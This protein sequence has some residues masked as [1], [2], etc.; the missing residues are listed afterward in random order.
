[1][2]TEIS[3]ISFQAGDGGGDRYRTIISEVRNV[4]SV[5]LAPLADLV[6]FIEMFYALSE[7]LTIT[8]LGS[9]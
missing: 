6:T 2:R 8:L 9:I 4:L 1:L 7:Y 5:Q 3:P